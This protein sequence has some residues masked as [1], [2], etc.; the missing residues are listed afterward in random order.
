[1][2]FKLFIFLLSA[3]FLLTST[4]A[5]V[6]AQT[7]TIPHDT[8]M[9]AQIVSVQN[10]T[11]SSAFEILTLK[12]IDGPQKGKEV[13][14]E[15]DPQTNPNTTLFAGEDIV[16][17]QTS[18]VGVG[19]KYYF[20]DFDRQLPILLVILAF[21]A[22]IV[23]IAGWKGIGGVLGIGMSLVV[24][25]SYI[26]PQILKGADPLS[27]CMTGAIAILCTTTYIAHG[28]SKQTTIALV[29]TLCAL[30]MT[31]FLAQFVVHV[32]SLTGYGDPEAGD[33][34]FGLGTLINIKG[35]L[36]GGIIL[37]T[38]G[39]L[40]DITITQVAAI[41]SLHKT[42]SQFLFKDL[43]DHGFR[44]GREHAISLVNTLVL[45]YAGGALSLFI[46]FLYNPNSQ[47]LWVILN[48]EMFNEEVMKT[49]AGT[50][51]LLLAVPI[52]TILASLLYDKRVIQFFK[53]FHYALLH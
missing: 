9:K 28:F 25:F 46:F 4:Y 47:P 19:S 36:L 42:N 33:L 12:I 38:V 16:I 53:D 13:R 41:F 34:H 10:P 27:V 50:A 1:M 52:V 24:I 26:I 17:A 51:G 43:F 32:T 31:F 8:F 23:V 15:Y 49:I 2:R 18:A 30:V 21:L 3:L 40:N 35:L 29:S 48:S 7:K 44:I 6:F 22:L 39:A 37:T 5:K 20:V 11:N 45:A 14:I